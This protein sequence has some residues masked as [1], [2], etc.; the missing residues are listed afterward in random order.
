MAWKR[1]STY[2]GRDLGLSYDNWS[3]SVWL[4]TAPIA[5]VTTNHLVHDQHQ[6]FPYH[7]L[8]P[9]LFVAIAIQVSKRLW[10]HGCSDL[11]RT[12][13]CGCSRLRSPT[14]SRLCNLASVIFGAVCLFASYQAF[15]HLPSVLCLTLVLAMAPA[16]ATIVCDF[17]LRPDRLTATR[18]A[19]LAICV[20]AI[21]LNDYRLTP[22]GFGLAL[23]AL[24]AHIAANFFDVLS[25][26]SESSELDEETENDDGLLVMLLAA[27]LPLFAATHIAETPKAMGFEFGVAPVI[28]ILSSVVGGIALSISGSLFMRS[29]KCSDGHNAN[30]MS[31]EAS[32]MAG[33]VFIWYALTGRA[34]VISGWQVFAYVVAFLVASTASGYVDDAYTAEGYMRIY[35][36]PTWRRFLGL[37]PQEGRT[38]VGLPDSEQLDSEVRT[39]NIA[40]CSGKFSAWQ[41]FRVAL[42][43]IALVGWI[44]IS[45]KAL[46]R[47]ISFAEREMNP[48]PSAPEKSSRS[49]D[50]VVSY[51]DEPLPELISTLTSFLVLPNVASLTHRVILYA[52]DSDS[53]ASELQINMTAGLPPSTTVL[54]RELPNKGREGETFLHHMIDNYDDPPGLADHT[55]FLQAEMHDPLYMRPRIT[56]YLVPQTGFLSLWHMDTLCTSSTTCRDHATW[57]PPPETLESV[58]K[59]AN[60]GSELVDMVPTY[61]GQFIAS[62]TRIRSSEKSMYE[63]LRRRFTESTEENPLWGYDLE[64]LWGVVMKCPG[65]K[66]VADRCP[67]LLAGMLGTVGELE[68]C[69]C[70]DY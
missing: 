45:F 43:S 61:R 23:L 1:S 7:I 2:L 17:L 58:F 34:I 21:F 41:L 56:Q 16:C 57:N 4:L 13:R 49:F 60:N 37:Q 8:I 67:S 6:H 26:G 27:V 53:P 29:Q 59:A 38:I 9:Q 47:S 52:K 3:P 10:D 48:F 44:C 22:P 54:V 24:G 64:R 32:A 25:Q 20:F 18:F 55:L 70:V 15:P 66:R 30:T 65:G 5:I 69:Q 42:L 51:H 33:L 62:A 40:R 14:W 31:I 68:D 63:D 36:M 46:H 11:W 12:I 39:R 28:F 19:L 35:H 50:I